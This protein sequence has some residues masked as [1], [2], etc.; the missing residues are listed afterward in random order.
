M[1]ETYE[2]CG[3]RL[4]T[5]IFFLGPLDTRTFH[6]S[7]FGII[8]LFMRKRIIIIIIHIPIFSPSLHLFSLAFFN[9]GKED[10]QMING[11]D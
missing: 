4:S 9:L 10:L 1:N 11:L 8:F 7:C 5:K 2:I 3:K 6:S